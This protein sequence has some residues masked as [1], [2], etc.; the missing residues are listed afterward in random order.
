MHGKSSLIKIVM[1]TIIIPVLLFC[2]SVS[3]GISAQE[4]GTAEQFQPE[5]PDLELPTVV[6]EYTAIQRED[7]E[8]ILPEEDYISLPKFS[9][10]LPEAEIM[11]IESP[12]FEIVMPEQTE[13]PERRT[14]SFFSEG[15]IGG[16]SDNHLIGDIALYKRGEV[17]LYQFRFSHE[18]IDGYG[19]NAPGDGFFDRREE[20]SG[21]VELG[22]KSHTAQLSAE[23]IEKETGLQDFSGAGS[24]IHRSLY[25][26]GGYIYSPDTQFS[27]SLQLQG[28]SGSQYI[29]A[30]EKKSEIFADTVVALNYE[31]E[32]L[33]LGASADYS[34]QEAPDE[35]SLQQSAFHVRTIYYGSRFDISAEAGV[36]WDVE[37]E[38][39]FPW[40]IRLQGAAGER[41]QYRIEGGFLIRDIL[42]R[43]LWED[44]S[45]LGTAG[46]IDITRGWT[47]AV[48]LD[49]NAGTR[50]R[51]DSSA[52]WRAL[53]GVPVPDDLDNRDPVSGLFSFSF[54]SAEEL[55]LDTS[56]SLFLTDNIEV[57]G[58]WEG[59][60]LH[61]SG[62]FE[63]IHMISA[64]LLYE[65][66]NR[67]F[68]AGIDGN[69]SIDPADSLPVI[70]AQL[71]YRLSEGILLVL[72]GDDL[73]GPFYQDGRP[74]WG[75]YESRGFNITLKTEIS[76]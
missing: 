14:A 48:N 27:V 60:L 61:D 17:P 44:Y 35:S 55:E 53:T 11:R 67:N 40:N 73:L 23:Y 31:W 26:S 58:G 54:G 7:I 65:N 68:G 56:F 64:G 69:Y 32:K 20:L 6:L 45:L 33:L 3:H 30:Q 28:H 22:K 43:N 5:E 10:V 57:K 71:H 21:S 66:R 15:V 74:W 39:L 59:L 52:E 47:A 75:E 63:P 72:E 34:F 62:K 24:V 19:M 70:G 9:E 49:Y 41:W 50:L 18:G 36:H 46:G 37:N 42:Y 16:G 76:L 29:D 25:G 1:Y 13:S 51:I 38:F 4:N 8:T 2:L 12:S